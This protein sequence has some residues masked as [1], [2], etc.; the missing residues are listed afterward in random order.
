MSS[1]NT[2]GTIHAMF[3]YLI[4]N[5]ETSYA[6]KTSFSTKADQYEYNCSHCPSVR[7]PQKKGLW[8]NNVFPA[9]I[10]YTESFGLHSPH[11]CL[12]LLHVLILRPTSLDRGTGVP[13]P[14]IHSGVRRGRPD[15][16]ATLQQFRLIIQLL[17]A[18]DWDSRPFHTSLFQ[19]SWKKHVPRDIKHLQTATPT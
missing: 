13:K 16:E 5:A 15:G 8:S 2:V 18:D 6:N 11:V 14:G 19:E 9:H 1:H 4:T 7:L 3:I 17:L 12:R 10:C